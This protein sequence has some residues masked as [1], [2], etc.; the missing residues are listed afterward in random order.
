MRAVD[1]DGA[2]LTDARLTDVALAA[3]DLA[4]FTEVARA[5]FVG[6]RE[7]QRPV[8]EAGRF[9]DADL[10]L[11]TALTAVARFGFAPLTLDFDETADLVDVLRSG[12]GAMI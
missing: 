2:R 10:A 7:R 9:T 12:E 6:I 11:P 8:W 4:D 5:R 1:D 3:L